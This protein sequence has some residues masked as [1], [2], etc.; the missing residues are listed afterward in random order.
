M[1]YNVSSRIRAFQLP[2]SECSEAHSKE[3]LTARFNLGRFQHD[4]QNRRYWPEPSDRSW[5][6]A[7]ISAVSIVGCVGMLGRVLA[8]RSDTRATPFANAEKH[9]LSCLLKFLMG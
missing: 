3:R 2:Y 9:A 8:A 4:G 6:V 5:A 7:A 1:N